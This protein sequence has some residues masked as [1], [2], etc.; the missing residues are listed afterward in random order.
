MTPIAR[1]GGVAGIGAA[2]ASPLPSFAWP[3]ECVPQLTYY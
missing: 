1:P 3:R 2:H